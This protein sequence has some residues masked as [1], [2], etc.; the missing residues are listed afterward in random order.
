MRVGRLLIVLMAGAV[1]AVCLSSNSL[2]VVY[3]A[4]YNAPNKWDNPDSIPSGMYGISRTP[5]QPGPVSIPVHPQL[6]L[7]MDGASQLGGYLGQIDDLH[8][9]RNGA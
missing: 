5:V 8:L 1:L 6:P 7:V 2:A 9:V 3:L 4:G